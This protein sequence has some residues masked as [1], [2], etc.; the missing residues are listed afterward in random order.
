MKL[1]K[2]RIKTYLYQIVY[3]YDLFVLADNE[4]NMLK[5]VSNY[6]TYKLDEDAKVKKYELIDLKDK[7]NR[8]I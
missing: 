4:I 8:V 3:H 6:P 2:V 7:T 1:W 5:E